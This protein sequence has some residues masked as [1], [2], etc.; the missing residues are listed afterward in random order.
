MKVL[1]IGQGGREH[2][3]VKFFR[4]SMSVTEIHVIPGNDGMTKE[5]MCHDL[6]WRNSE[7]IIG[8]C[9]KT[10]IDFVFIG[11]EE[12]LVGG[13]ADS[14]RER[15]ILVVGPSGPAAQ[16]EGSKIFAKEF[17]V[18]AGVPTARSV[19]VASVE[20]TIKASHLFK[21]PY[22]L[23]AD[24]LAAGKGVFICATLSEL[25]RA[26]GDLFDRK[27]FGVAGS[28]ALLE[29]CLEGWELSYLIL[30]NGQ[31]HVTLPLAQDHKRL[32]DNHQG[33]NT[34][35]MGTVAPLT[36]A[37][38]LFEQIE[39][40]IVKPTVSQLTQESFIYRGVLFIGI[41]VTQKGPIVLEYNTR[42]GD[43]E[44]Q[45][46]LPLIE[47]DGGVL[48]K[49]LSQGE[50]EPI[51]FKALHSCCVILAAEGYPESPK[52]NVPIEGD[53]WMEQNS[54]YFVHAGTKREG[55]HWVTNGGRV[56]GAVGVGSSVK[57]AVRNAYHQ[58]QQ[59]KWPGQQFRMDIGK[60]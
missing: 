54:S 2:A 1:I 58:A 26:A 9:H 46:I 47:N 44:T 27:I 52:K 60:S 32:R 34:G 22:V 17:M 8:F 53:L 39:N 55:T 29:E 19:V 6:N 21:P 3:L 5:A 15:G 38:D 28:R 13:L 49:K 51:L 41:M 20:E 56:L 59:A 45:V 50:L 18:R 33:P 31:K 40:Q 43:P 42:F 11:P 35:G 48:F 36:I 4:R 30:T 10:E 23:K 25:E 7:D 12:P 24:G 16:L 57:E 14:L 37:H